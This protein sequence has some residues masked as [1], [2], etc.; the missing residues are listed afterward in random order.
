MRHVWHRWASG[1]STRCALVSRH[2]LGCHDVIPLY[3][4]H[5][6]F[7]YN[8]THAVICDM[9]ILHK[10]VVVLFLCL[11]WFIHMS[12]ELLW[13]DVFM[14][15]VTRWCIKWFAR[16]T[17]WSVIVLLWDMTYSHVTCLT[18]MW[19]DAR[20]MWHDSLIC[21]MT[22]SCVTRWCVT[23]HAL[24]PCILLLL[25]YFLAPLVRHDSN[26]SLCVSKVVPLINESCHVSMSHVTY[27]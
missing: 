9:N 11:T 3:V 17:L 27:E 24:Q 7:I 25:V 18:H 19:H 2:S 26:W 20:H 8:M 5:D 23:W 13:C 12:R 1:A 14:R 10:R 22:R 4:W 16:R 15:D 6:S 21:N